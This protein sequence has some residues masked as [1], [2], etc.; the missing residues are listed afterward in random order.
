VADAFGNGKKIKSIDPIIDG[1]CGSMNDFFELLKHHL[2]RLNIVDAS[3]IVFSAD[4]GQGIWPR[5]DH[6]ID[7][8]KIL[9]AK[10]IL[11]YTHAKQN[12][13]I[14]SESISKTLK[15]SDKETEKLSKQIREHLW[16]GDIDRI[17]DII[18]ERLLGRRKFLKTALKKLDRY[19]G[20]HCRF[21][22]RTFKENGLPTGS[23]TVESAIR[24]VINFRVKGAGMF[25]KRENAEKM[26]F[27]RSYGP[28]YC[29]EYSREQDPG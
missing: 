24:R 5:I 21:Q 9:G 10:R 28:Q 22:Y 13:G 15:L 26:I 16:N 17:C 19:F 7:E 25:W 2:L 4:G 1:S 14:V 29:S 27:L 18:R 11:D 23:G 20:D 8:L 3:E 12:I 6:L